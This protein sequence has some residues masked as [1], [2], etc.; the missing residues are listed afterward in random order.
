VGQNG[1]V[2]HNRVV[3]IYPAEKLQF[4]LTVKG[5]EDTFIMLILNSTYEKSQ[6]SA[7]KT[8]YIKW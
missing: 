1:S 7:L 5:W 4:N 3:I 6:R 2:M 8:V